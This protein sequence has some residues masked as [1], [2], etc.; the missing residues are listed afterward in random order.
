MTPAI[1]VIIP[2]RNKGMLIH[3][4]IDSVLSQTALPE[5]IV[6]DDAST[7]I[8]RDFVRA[9]PQRHTGVRAILLDT[10][11]GG[12]HCRNQ[13]LAIARGEFVIFLDSDDLFSPTCCAGR[14]AA[15]TAHPEYD[16]WVFPMRVFRENPD[17]TISEWI[18]DNHTDH[19]TAF[20]SHRLPWSI[21]QPLWRRSVLESLG[22]FD[23]SFERL[24]DP[25]LHTRAILAG[26]RVRCFPK[27]EPDCY[28]RI[29]E[30]RTTI[31]PAV[32]AKQ[33]AAASI[34]YYKTFADR[35]GERLP[36][37]SGVL[38][39]AIARTINDWRAN[40]IP[41]A[42]LRV[43]TSDLIGICRIPRHQRILSGYVTMSL[44][45]PFHPPGIGTVMRKLLR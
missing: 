24:Q 26:A 29:A 9:L 8:S 27:A 14:I 3:A 23:E 32:A 22:G 43:M 41:T 7:D 42:D 1:S 16:L 20:L 6:V 13:G 40:K 37:L 5:I 36:Q 11:R 33:H 4:T 45:I 34:H 21:M 18:P 31:D 44:A 35:I 28:Y 12:S 38:Q 10:P 19:L 17:I 30:C 39:S 2:N 15:A 25:E